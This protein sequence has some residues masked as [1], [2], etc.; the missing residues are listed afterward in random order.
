MLNKDKTDEIFIEA[1]ACKSRMIQY[2]P[3]EHSFVESKDLYFIIG[4]FDRESFLE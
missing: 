2:I 4:T 3:V 1:V